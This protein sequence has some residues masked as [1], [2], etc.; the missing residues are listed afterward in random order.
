MRLVPGLL[1]LLPEQ[2]PQRDAGNLGHLQHNTARAS[3]QMQRHC[4]AG[5]LQ[6]GWWLMVPGGGQRVAHTRCPPAG[7]C[8]LTW[9]L[10]WLS[11]AACA[12]HIMI[13]QQGAAQTGSSPPGWSYH[14]CTVGPGRRCRR[15][16]DAATLVTLVKIVKSVESRW[17]LMETCCRCWQRTQHDPCWSLGIWQ[18]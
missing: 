1:L 7:Q 14:P 3:A 11:L 8:A 9:D 2:G 5:V 13:P 18:G 4:E 12:A 15:S 16:C 6:L 17:A 10:C